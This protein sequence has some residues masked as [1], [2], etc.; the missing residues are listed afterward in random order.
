MSYSNIHILRS[1]KNYLKYSNLQLHCCTNSKVHLFLLLHPSQASIVKTWGVD[2]DFH[3]T[4]PWPDRHEWQEMLPQ[5]LKKKIIQVQIPLLLQRH[6]AAFIRYAGFCVDVMCTIFYI[7][8]RV[9]I[10]VLNVATTHPFILLLLL[11]TLV[12]WEEMGNWHCL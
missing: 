6:H 8:C 1:I 12:K 9:S 4:T 10:C 3:W 7:M 2:L 11:S 5:F